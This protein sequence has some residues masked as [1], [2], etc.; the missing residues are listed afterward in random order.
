MHRLTHLAGTQLDARL[1]ADEPPVVFWVL[2]AI[3]AHGPHLPLETDTII[4]EA[5]AERAAQ[6]LSDR[7]GVT[8]LA[9]PSY[10]ATAAECASALEGTVHV[11][12]DVAQAGIEATLRGLL[13]AGVQRLCVITL[14]FDPAH[15]SALEAALESLE[16]NERARV[17]YPRLASRENAQRVGGEFAT[18]DAH[19]GCFETSLVLAAQPDAVDD[20]Y[21]E[22]EAN[23]VGLVDGIREGKRSFEAL[24]M[25]E[26]YCGAPAEASRDRGHELFAT[27]ADV[28]VEAC[29]DAWALESLG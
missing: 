10:T 29:G 16:E 8:T 5:L 7:T 24:G 13:S 23:H 26:A 18:G 3:E 11:P 9:A 27:L 6:Q 1:S 28:V 14:H 4:G 20:T 19:A 12:E 17:A 2:G 25:P 21:R 15:T 22:L